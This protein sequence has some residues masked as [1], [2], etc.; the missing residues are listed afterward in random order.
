MTRDMYWIT[1]MC[2]ALIMLIILIKEDRIHKALPSKLNRV[3]RLMV[4][5]AMLHC[6]Q[7]M[8]WGLCFSH[9]IESESVFFVSSETFHVSCVFAMIFWLYFVLVYLKCS[10]PIQTVILTTYSMLVAVEVALVIANINHPLLFTIEQGEY[11]MQPFRNVTFFL[12]H[13]AYLT[14]AIVISVTIAHRIK[15]YHSLKQS[16]MAVLYSSLLPLLLGIYQY[17]DPN[18]PLY[19]VGLALSI[20]ILY[21]FVVSAEREGLQQSKTLFLQNMSH[22]IRTSLNSIYGFAQLLGLP[23]GTWTEKERNDYCTH[24]HNSYNMLDMLLNDL[25]VSTRYDT[26]KYSVMVTSVNVIEACNEAIEAVSV[27]KPSSAQMMVESELPEGFT[28]N[29]DGRR[30]RQILQNLLTNAYQFMVKGKILLHVAQRDNVVEFTIIEMGTKKQEQKTSE[31]SEKSLS[32]H[33]TGQGLRLRVSEKMA[34]LIGG[35]IYKNVDYTEGNSY[36][37]RLKIA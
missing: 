11:V 34:E 8:F 14:T 1:A 16:H 20:L 25:M 28:I 3:F 12:Q 23:E 35:N 9:V 24:I 36:T 37:F 18:A 31:T 5:V 30:I 15:K 29:S 32:E 22:E 26:H 19:S 27:C 33:K 2:F 13:F 4:L 6:V 17:C 10:R 21:V 7:D